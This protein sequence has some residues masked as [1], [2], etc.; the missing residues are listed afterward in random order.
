MLLPTGAVYQLQLS[1]LHHRPGGRHPGSRG[2]PSP[3][4]RGGECHPRPQVRRGPQSSPLG[5]LP[6]QRH[7][8]AVQSLPRARYRVMA[9]NPGSLDNAHRPGRA[10]GNHQD[11]PTT[12]LRPGRTHHPQG[13]APHPAP[14]PGLALAEPVQRRSRPIARPAAPLLTTP[15]ASDHPPHYPIASPTRARLAL[16][17]LL[18]P[19]AGLISPSDTAFGRQH[20][21]GVAT[22][23]CAQPDWSGSRPRG[24]YPPPIIPCFLGVAASF[25][26]IWV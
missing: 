23:P 22:T 24:L 25:R 5:T 1:R 6:R 10:G 20:P 8:A 7:L 16:Q 14:A 9:H 2:R 18:L 12:L 3:P 19:S 13:A 15:T 4:R 17:C 21:L 26:W 11:P